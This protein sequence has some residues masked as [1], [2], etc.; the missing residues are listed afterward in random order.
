MPRKKNQRKK[1]HVRKGDT[2]RVISGNDKGKEGRILRV[3][4]EDERVII[5]GVNMR[6]RHTRPCA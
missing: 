3:Y 5:E 4:P 1:L 6:I 2:V